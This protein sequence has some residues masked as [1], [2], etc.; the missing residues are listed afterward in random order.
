MDVYVDP[1]AGRTYPLDPRRWR[2]DDGAPLTVAPQIGIGPADVDASVRSLW[3]YRAALPG[4]I[5]RPV[6]LGEGCTPLIGMPWGE[7]D[8]RF[9]LEWFS[10]TGSFKDR[11]TSVMISLLA[12]AGVEAVL[13]DSSG[14]GGSS[15]A[16]YCAAAGIR[17][18]ILVPETT[19]PTKVMQA[20]AYGAEVVPVPGDRA[21]TGRQALAVGRAHIDVPGRDVGFADRVAEARLVG[22]RLHRMRAARAERNAIGRFRR[23]AAATTGSHLRARRHGQHRNHARDQSPPRKRRSRFFENRGSR[24]RGNDGSRPK[25]GR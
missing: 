11:G 5:E 12:Q 13:E 21:A 22:E 19:S 24:L 18:R 4:G 2:G 10:P 9:K 6:S 3:R 14:N 15:V 23:H 8:L 16:A 25:L 17:A 1:R 20:R 7:H